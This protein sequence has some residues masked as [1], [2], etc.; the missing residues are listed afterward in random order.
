MS[1]AAQKRAADKA[2]R[3]QETPVAETTPVDNPEAPPADNPP[4]A[5]PPAE[6]ETGAGTTEVN[7]EPEAPAAPKTLAVARD[8]AGAALASA[9]GKFFAGVGSQEEL[10][11]ARAAWRALRS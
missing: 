10:D 1:T 7:A 2:A 6:D 8:E 9:E 11:A 4:P 5:A 3:E